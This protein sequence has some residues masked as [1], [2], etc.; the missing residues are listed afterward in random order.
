MKL[1]EGTISSKLDMDFF[2]FLVD[3]AM[4]RPPNPGLIM[5]SLLPLIL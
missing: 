1:N 3:L 5:G 4:I 2:S